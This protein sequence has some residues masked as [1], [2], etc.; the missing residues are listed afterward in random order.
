MKKLLICFVICASAASSAFAKD[1]GTRKPAANLVCSQ[2]ALTSAKALFLLHYGADTAAAN[3]GATFST[4]TQE[5]SL[6]SPDKKMEY[7]VLQ[8]IAEIGKNGE[9]RIRMIYAMVGNTNTDQDCVLMGE[10]ILDLSSL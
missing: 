2:K 7:T 8:T 6:K 10:E 9:Y 3:G 4:L 1:S 5:P